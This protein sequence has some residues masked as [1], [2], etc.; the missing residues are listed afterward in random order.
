MSG[1]PTSLAVIGLGS[2]GQKH[3]KVIGSCP[4]TELV[5]VCDVKK[6]LLESFR[7][8]VVVNENA[9]AML[10]ASGAIGAI[11]A[12]P[13]EQHLPV[14]KDCLLRGVACLKEKPFARNSTEAEELVALVA[15]TGQVLQVAVQ[16]QHGL[17]FQALRKELQSPNFVH[18][19]DYRY[20]LGLDRSESHP[21]WRGDLNLSGGGAILDMGYH[22]LDLLTSIFG[23]PELISAVECGSPTKESDIED[24]VLLTVRYPL[25]QC[26]TVLL[27]RHL[28]PAEEV[29]TFWS[30]RGTVKLQ[31]LTVTRTLN[32]VTTTIGKDESS[33]ELMHRQLHDFLS[34]KA[35]IDDGSRQSLNVM[36]V[37][38]GCYRAL[39][40]SGT[41]GRR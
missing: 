14:V 3:V 1:S 37:V 4:A 2:R 13:H 19:F 29:A 16:R 26:G 34:A 20:V 41:S 23:I 15:R 25:G 8:K 12:V 33:E 5:G 36:E 35:G 30:D 28:S 24:G 40:H 17:A 18:V 10:D 39:R 22:V 9:G 32:D 6:P 38:E 11:V 31:G 21:G 7:G 27:A